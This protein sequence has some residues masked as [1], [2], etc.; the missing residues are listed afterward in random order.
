M[1]GLVVPKTKSEPQS[2][3][4]VKNPA[5][6]FEIQGNVGIQEV[7]ENENENEVEVDVLKTMGRS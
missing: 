1:G 4:Q 7:K 2:I 6:K 3:F 5:I